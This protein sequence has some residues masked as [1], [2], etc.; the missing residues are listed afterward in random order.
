MS[1][2]S[3]HQIIEDALAQAALHDPN[4]SPFGLTYEQGVA[5]QMGMAAAY[6]HA[7]E[8]IPKPAPILAT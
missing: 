4:H 7:L 8:M 1:Q 3:G 5:Y 6:L 2:K